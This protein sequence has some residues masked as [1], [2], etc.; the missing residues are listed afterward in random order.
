MKENKKLI[1]EGFVFTD[2]V[3]SLEDAENS[4][5]SFWSVIVWC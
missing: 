2:Q 5:N 1:K 3:I 4:K